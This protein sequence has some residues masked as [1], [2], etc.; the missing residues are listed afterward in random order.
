[1][2]HIFSIHH[3]IRHGGDEK[4]VPAPRYFSFGYLDGVSILAKGEISHYAL[5]GKGIPMAARSEFR[6]TTDTFNGLYVTHMSSY[7][8]C[9]QQTIEHSTSLHEMAKLHFAHGT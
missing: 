1:M 6:H 5:R 3:R 7:G 9:Q 2:R 4:F 8:C